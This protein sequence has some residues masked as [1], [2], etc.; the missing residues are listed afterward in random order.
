MEQLWTDMEQL[1]SHFFDYEKKRTS[2]RFLKRKVDLSTAS[3]KTQHTGTKKRFQFVD[4]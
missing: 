2:D 4:K 3:D 1:T